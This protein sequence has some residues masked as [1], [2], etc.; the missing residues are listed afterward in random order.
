[1]SLVKS[2]KI[3]NG[4]RLTTKLYSEGHGSTSESVFLEIDNLDTKTIEQTENNYE[5]VFVRFRDLLTDKPWCCDSREDVLSMCQ[6]LA[7]SM[8]ENLLIRK[9]E[10]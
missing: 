10:K 3:R 9:E 6:V 5:E 7:D 4:S 1:M 8:R 2:E